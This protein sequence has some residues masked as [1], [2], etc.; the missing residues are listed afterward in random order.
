M[1]VTSK[2]ANTQRNV[3]IKEYESQQLKIKDFF[4]VVCLLV[5][6]FEKKFHRNSIFH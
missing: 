1:E 5:I 4:V 3:I 6:M 2:Y